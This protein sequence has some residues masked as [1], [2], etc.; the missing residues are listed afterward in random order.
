M[1]NKH[2]IRIDSQNR[3]IVGLTDDTSAYPDSV[4]DGDIFTHDGGRLFEMFVNDEWLTNPSLT[5]FN[6]VF[7]YKWDGKQALQRT[8][9]E[10]DADAVESTPEERRQQAYQTEQIIEWYGDMITVDRAK[11]LWLYYAAEGYPKE[12]ITDELE[13]KIHFAKEDIRARY[14][15]K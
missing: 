3:I 7:I 10:I 11:D 1:N 4:Q 6:G 15:D 5:D 14:P 8:Q 12:I 13:P 2:Y 9:D